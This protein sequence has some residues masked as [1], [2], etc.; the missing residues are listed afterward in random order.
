[1]A[2]VR[3]MV[4]R[5]AA[6]TPPQPPPPPAQFCGQA[7]NID[8][9]SANRAYTWFS[10]LYFA[11]GSNDFLGFSGATQTTLKETAPG[12]YRRVTSCT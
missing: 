5:L 6:T 3:K 10:L 9:V 2:A 1:M 8:H 4:E 12:T 11:R 7:A